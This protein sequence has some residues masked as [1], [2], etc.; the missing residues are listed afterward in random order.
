MKIYKI[1]INFDHRFY[2][3]PDA[4][5]M[6]VSYAMIIQLPCFSRTSS[7]CAR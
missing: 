3:N 2:I 1:D 5:L 4:W 7:Y 6:N